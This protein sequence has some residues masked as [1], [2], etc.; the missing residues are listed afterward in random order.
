MAAKLNRS[1]ATTSCIDLRW[2]SIGGEGEQNWQ[3]LS[4]DDELS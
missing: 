3:F 4:D 2:S 1:G